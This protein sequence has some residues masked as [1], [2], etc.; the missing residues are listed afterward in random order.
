VQVRIVPPYGTLYS[1]I[2]LRKR[3]Q[4]SRRRNRYAG[5]FPLPAIKMKEVPDFLLPIHLQD[6]KRLCSL[7]VAFG[8][9]ELIK[10]FHFWLFPFSIL[11]H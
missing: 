9:T 2:F 10:S 3:K 4:N 5:L 1:F 6:L 7:M 11:E 8:S